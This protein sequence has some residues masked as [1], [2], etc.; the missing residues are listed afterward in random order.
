MEMT[1]ESLVASGLT[2]ELAKMVMDAHK[3]S[4]AGAYVPKARF[5]EVNSQLSNAN[6]Q[7]KDRDEQI[8]GLKKFEGDNVALQTKINELQEASKKKDA[9]MQQAL[10][11][12][13]INNAMKL[14]LSGKVHDVDMV[15]SQ[16]A[17]DKVS[18]DKDGNL[19]GFDDQIAALKESKKF[20]F[21]AEA[22]PKQNPYAGFK[23]VG[24]PPPEGGSP[25][26]ETNT[27]EAFGASLAKRKIATAD[28]AKKAQDHYFKG[29]N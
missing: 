11:M 28:A 3:A 6:T 21:V 2:N 18:V 4:I 14:K 10:S 8:A 20:L 29:G 5:D 9:E 15:L 22:A 13:R 19:V 12:E 16:I 23:P 1:L 24:T 17:T 26:E 7:L 27:A 25:A